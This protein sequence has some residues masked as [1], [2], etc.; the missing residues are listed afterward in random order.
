MNTFSM[1]CPSAKTIKNIGGVHQMAGLPDHFFIASPSDSVESLPEY[2]GTNRVGAAFE[3]PNG[4]R[5]V[6]AK[7]IYLLIS[8]TNPMLLIIFK[9]N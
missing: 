5:L 4:R 7:L 1:E 8:F 2:G 3:T 9:D 6:S